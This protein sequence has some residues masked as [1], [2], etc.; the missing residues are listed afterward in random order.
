MNTATR[1]AAVIAAVSLTLLAGC[2]GGDNKPDAGPGIPA[3]TTLGEWGSRLKIDE[4]ILLVLG[5]KAGGTS[6]SVVRLQVLEVR[7]GEPSDLDTFTGVP[8]GVTPWYVSVAEHNRG[9]ADVDT[10]EEMGWFLKLDSDL[11]LPPVEVQ[12]KIKDCPTQAAEPTLEFGAERLDCLVF[13]VPDKVRPVAVDY[14]RNNRI[15][16]VSWRIPSAMSEGS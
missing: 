14:L 1:V 9:P 3:G 4:S 7:K 10:T 16:T 2:S 11:E 15:D 8:A 5:D 13:L 6:G 12:G